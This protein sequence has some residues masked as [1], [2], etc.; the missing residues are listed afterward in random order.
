L[1]GGWGHVKIGIAALISRRMSMSPAD[2]PT[3]LSKFAT[4]DHAVRLP[5]AAR[6]ARSRDEASGG[7]DIGR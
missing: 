3:A 2:I 6:K 4:S 1:R 5:E 7:R